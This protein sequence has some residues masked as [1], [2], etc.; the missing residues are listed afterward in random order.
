VAPS[1]SFSI[2][3]SSINFDN[4][5]NANSYTNTKSTVLTTSTNACNGYVVRLFKTDV[6]ISSA[7]PLHTINDFS[8]GSYVSPANW[9]SSTGFGYTSDDPLIQG[10]NKFSPPTCAGGGVAPCYAPISP[11]AP[12]DIV[13]DNTSLV[14]GT[15]IINQTFTITYRVTTLST[16]PAGK[17]STALVYTI[18]PQY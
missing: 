4:L 17:Y 3:S 15:P 8:G 18:I 2:S 5:N 9:A 6:L 10:V 14:T 13:A 7:N 11:S 12:G 16:Q 1:L